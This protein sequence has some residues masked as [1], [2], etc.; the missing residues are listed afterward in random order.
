MYTY[1]DLVLRDVLP[2]CAI[3]ACVAV[4]VGRA[5]GLQRVK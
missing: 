4:V 3:I 2:R 5:V 1:I